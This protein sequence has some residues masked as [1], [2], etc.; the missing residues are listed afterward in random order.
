MCSWLSSSCSEQNLPGTIRW[1]VSSVDAAAGLV[2]SVS[3]EHDRTIPIAQI[4]KIRS[5][6]R[7]DMLQA[8][9]T[10]GDI[11]INTNIEN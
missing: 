1:N 9:L 2:L 4:S 5:S 6:D 3:A 8:A 7:Y 11:G 10:I